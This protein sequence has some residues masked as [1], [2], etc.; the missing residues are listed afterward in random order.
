MVAA[1]GLAQRDDL[2]WVAAVL[3]DVGLDPGQRAL[4]VF[5]SVRVV[6]ALEGQAVGRQAGDA[7]VGGEVVA[8]GGRRV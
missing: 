7:A 3:R 4:D 1:R 2:G 6:A 8:C 5:S